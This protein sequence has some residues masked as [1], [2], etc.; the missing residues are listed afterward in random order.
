MSTFLGFE[1]FLITAGSTVQNIQDSFRTAITAYGWQC[2]RQALPPI[3]TAF[4]NMTSPAL[5]FDGIAG[6]AT[7]LATTLP[8]WLGCQMASPFTPTIMYLGINYTPTY[9][10]TAFTLDWS[11]NGSS[12]TTHATW[13]S[14][15]VWGIHERRKYAITSAPAKNYWRL[16]VTAKNGGTYT[17][18]SEWALEDASA[19]IITNN[20]FIDL[21]PPVTETIGNS[22]SKEEVRMIFNSGTLTVKGVPE[23]LTALPQM[24]CFDTPTA[25]AVT[26][27]VTI[28]GV[29]VSYVGSA[30]YTAAQN[31]RGLYEALRASNDANFLAWNWLINTGGFTIL[32][33]KI[34]P[35]AN[36]TIT[37]SNITSYF[38]GSYH[39]P[40]WCSFG[41]QPDINTQLTID[42]TNGFIYYLQVH[43]RGLAL[44]IKN[45][46]GF[47]GP[48]HACYGDNTT[49]V[50][51]I[52]ISDVPGVSCSI[53]ELVW[54]TDDVI[55]STGALGKFTHWWGVSQYGTQTKLQQNIETNNSAS[56][57]W[58]KH[59]NAY[60][61]QDWGTGITT[62][63]GTN[64]ITGYSAVLR[65]EGIFTGG[66]S[67]TAW[68]AHKMICDPDTAW[69]Y[70]NDGYGYF[71]RMVGPVFPSLDW[72]RV[73]GAGV[74]DEQLVL[75]PSIDF[76]AT[77]TS[78]ISST[79]VTIPVTSTT[80]WPSTGYF[81][82]DGEVI[83][84]GG[85]TS[86]SFTTCTR[87]R[88]ATVAY[89]HFTSDVCYVGA[90]LVKINTG[91]LFAGYVKPT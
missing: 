86:N 61:M 57:I 19:N 24:Y 64:Y 49:A 37:S 33:T 55:T 50:S 6:T 16:N 48:I 40:M 34:T 70:Q 23:L 69:L 89:N 76:T 87:A 13:S 2:L 77:L 83:Q 26:L 28:N 63:S 30:G 17:E 71:A 10:P 25:G 27:S 73:V 75:I 47:Y 32:A 39:A 42:R 3:S 60:S 29:T 84:Y 80:G 14:E 51:Q 52:P 15:L 65:A 54:G 85:K 62:N 18:I 67:G 58:T 44:A 1:S 72:Y 7:S 12:W 56:N 38:K 22:L 20:Q 36:I 79:D 11:D 45:N 74:T 81:V 31:N 41:Q 82:L 5:A 53:I 4:G 78:N 43:A 59:A 68:R 35:S 88:Y 66:D 46:A 90:W 8:A 21:I 91:L 9:A